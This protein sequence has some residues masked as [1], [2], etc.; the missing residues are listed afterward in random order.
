MARFAHECLRRMR[1][2]T[3]QLEIQLGPSTGDLQGRVGLHSGSVTGGVLR[4]EKARFQLFG[5]T[6]NTA[7]RMEST[8][9]PGQIQV[10]SDT[11]E[12]LVDAGK[13]H[14][15]V[16]RDELVTAKGKGE[17]QTY[18]VDLKAKGRLHST[19]SE[20]SDAHPSTA[21]MT[22][23]TSSRSIEQLLSPQ[24]L[25]QEKT[26]R[27]VEWNVE[28]LCGFLENIIDHRTAAATV[29]G[30]LISSVRPRMRRQDSQKKNGLLM[31]DELSVIRMSTS[32]LDEAVEAVEIPRFDARL[33]R[34]LCQQQEHGQGTTESPL[35]AEVRSQL[36][37][38]VSRI[39]SMYRDVPFHNFEVRTGLLDPWMSRLFLFVSTNILIWC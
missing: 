18:W 31:D 30:G 11:A 10:S 28:L 36:Y 27:L 7:S 5:D 22:D 23:M 9:I 34:Q 29:A 33:V 15:V 1:K 35:N 26:M 16:P 39:S 13:G 32:I 14:W 4:G 17:M 21:D 2:L 24:D 19:I 12:L 3:K 6:M 8:G 37:E 38:Y 25:E 20:V